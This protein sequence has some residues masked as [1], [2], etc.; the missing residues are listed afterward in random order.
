MLVFNNLE[1]VKFKV[2]ISTI[3][4]KKYRRNYACGCFGTYRRD[5]EVVSLASLGEIAWRT[6]N[7]VSYLFLQILTV[8]FL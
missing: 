6:V 1:F 4:T 3:W 8:V 2:L 7:E 5:G